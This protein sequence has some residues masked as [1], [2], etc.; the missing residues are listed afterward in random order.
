MKQAVQD[1][2]ELDEQWKALEQQ[3]LELRDEILQNKR[4]KDKSI[5]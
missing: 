4:K 5:N 3:H 1:F 2:K